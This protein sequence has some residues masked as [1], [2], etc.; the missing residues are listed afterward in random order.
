MLHACPIGEANFVHLYQIECVYTLVLV[1]LKLYTVL[2][3]EYN[4]MTFWEFHN[5]C[6]S[7]Y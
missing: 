6:Q 2:S 4:A 5:A 7:G 3:F 1:C